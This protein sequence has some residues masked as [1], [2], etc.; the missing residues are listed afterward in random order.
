MRAQGAAVQGALAALGLCAAYLTWQREPELN[1]GEVVVLDVSRKSLEKIRYEDGERWMELFRLPQTGSTVWLKQ[2]VAEGARPQGL[3]DGGPALAPPPVRQLRGN[4]RAEK[5]FVRFAPLRAARAFASLSDDKRKEVGLVDSKRTLTVTAGGVTHRVKLGSSSLAGGPP[6]IEDEEGRYYLLG[7]SLVSELDPASQILVDR[8][9][10][11][12]KV[13]ELDELALSSGGK[14]RRF[15]QKS[16]AGGLKLF[17]KEAPEQADDRAR[18]WHERVFSQLSVTLLYGSDEAPPQ[19][20]VPALRVDYFQRGSP[21]GFMELAKAGTE[22]VGRT[23]HTAGWVRLGGNM[24]DLIA[25]A[26]KLISP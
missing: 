23:E 2:G 12:L 6:F 10:H 26:Q 25:E 18:N 9:L 13:G 11:A 15:V 19:P 17:P 22:T 14:E 21:V 4:E 1:Q 7:A 16:A 8:R 3:P 24:D 5:L 20:P